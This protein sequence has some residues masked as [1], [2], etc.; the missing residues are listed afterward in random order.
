MEIVPIVPV[1]WHLTGNRGEGE[2]FGHAF[3][4]L[5][6]EDQERKREV[7]GTQRCRGTKSYLY[8]DFSR[9]RGEGKK[10]AAVFRSLAFSLFTSLPFRKLIVSFSG[11][12][13]IFAL[14]LFFQFP[15]S[16]FQSI[17]FN[18]PTRTL[19]FGALVNSTQRQPDEGKAL[20]V[21]LELDRRNEI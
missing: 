11:F 2:G 13:C 9:E 18:G 8:R 15:I 5:F 14:Y 20:G 4:S 17:C 10:G 1:A 12:L 16:L 21:F 7:K 19:Y 6:K 3:G